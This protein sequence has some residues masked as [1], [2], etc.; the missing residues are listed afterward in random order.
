MKKYIVLLLQYILRKLSPPER[1]VIMPSIIKN[2]CGVLKDNR[3]LHVCMPNGE[4]IPGQQDFNL[5]NNVD[6]NG[7]AKITISFTLNLNER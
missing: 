3:F 6:D 7:M 4:I 5:I 1:I 2:Q